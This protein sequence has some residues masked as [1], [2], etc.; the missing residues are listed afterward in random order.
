MN[1]KIKIAGYLFII[2]FSTIGCKKSFLELKPY[3]SL[4]IDKAITDEPSMLAAL[5]GAYAGLRDVDVFGRSIL[6]NGDLYADNIYVS[7]QNSGRYIPQYTYQVT[8]N[9][10][11]VDGTWGGLYND[12][13][14]ANQIIAKESAIQGPNVSQ[15]V[16]EAYA[17]R[18]LNYFTLVQH[19]ARPYTENPNALGV[20]I[21]LSF[22]IKQLP[23]RKKVSEVYDQILSDLAQA[24][25]KVTKIINS[26]QFSPAAVKAL[27]AKVLFYQ[28]KYNEAKTVAEDLI[29]NSGYTLVD[30]AGYNAYWA[31]PSIQFDKKETLL[32]ISFDPLTRLGTNSL[33]YIYVQDGYGDMLA[34]DELYN[35][36]SSTD[37]R[38]SLIIPGTR[39]GAPALFVN[40]FPNG[41]A[42][43]E[44]DDDTKIIRLSEIY[45]IAAECEARVGT[46]AAALNYLNALMSKRDPSFAGYSSTG[47]QLLEDIIAERRK[48]LAFEGNRWSDLNRL[49]RDIS[50]NNQ[51]PSTARSLPF[52]DNRRI[53]P[54]PKWEMDA[55]MNMVQNPGY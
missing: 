3:S 15:Y 11:T 4:S 41:K 2:L 55:N 6:V 19:F 42:G 33:S 35:L 52:A 14:R 24:E 31:D 30:A 48:E 39:G 51:Y 1:N 10:G 43:K 29:A 12:I 34:T 17:L 49:K 25:V 53:F 28:G 16:G 45:L 40:K 13:L 47:S 32:E 37:V 36:Y 18:A 7:T 5:Y 27:K 44:N 38:K 9:D 26:S 20:P 50:R 21:V 46:E 54:I 23:E 22:N 8:V